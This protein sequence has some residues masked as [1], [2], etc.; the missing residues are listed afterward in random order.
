MSTKGSTAT[1]GLLNDGA[2]T[3]FRADRKCAPIATTAVAAST[4]AIASFH[5]AR[6]GEEFFSFERE[7]PMLAFASALFLSISCEADKSEGSATS[8]SLTDATNRYPR[9]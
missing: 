3:P 2:S 5:S 9:L 6:R 4:G 7:V 1:E 8:S